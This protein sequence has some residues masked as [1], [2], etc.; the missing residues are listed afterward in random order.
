MSGRWQAPS[1]V[2]ALAFA[3]PTFAAP[4]LV[5]VA[6][7]DL[8]VT[9]GALAPLADG[10]FSIEAPKMRA[11]LNRRTRPVIEA[12]VTYLGATAHDVPLGSGEMRRQFGLKLEAQDPCNLVYV[13]WRIEPESKIVVSVKRND[14]EHSSAACGNRGYIN[15]KP[16]RAA[17]VP[18]LKPGAAHTLR[19]ALEGLALQ[20]FIDD[21]PVWQGDVG[22]AARGL[23]GPVGLRSD[24]ARLRVALRSGGPLEGAEGLSKGCAAGE[25]D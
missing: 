22:E 19:A 1:A 20:V 24:N 8:C 12:R 17:P 3:A 11:V 9:E 18:A 13:M 6:A 10:A 4:A 23:S 5:P 2:L 15:L 14:G 25:S 21:A 7:Q 16:G